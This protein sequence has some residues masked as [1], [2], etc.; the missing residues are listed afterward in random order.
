MDDTTGFLTLLMNFIAPIA[1]GL[2]LLYVL[3]RTRRV[4]W[5]QRQQ[6]EKATEDLY[7]RVENERERAEPSA[8]R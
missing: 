5:R 4:D 3:L 1:L 7:E 8:R 6:T 2:G